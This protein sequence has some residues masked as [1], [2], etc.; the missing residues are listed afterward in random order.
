MADVTS[1]LEAQLE[2]A[3]VEVRAERDRLINQLL[4][5]REHAKMSDDA[6]VQL[7]EQRDRARDKLRDEVGPSR[8]WNDASVVAALA[9]EPPKVST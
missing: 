7:R 6:I 2:Q 9:D 3:L 1:T 8:R 5:A 4:A